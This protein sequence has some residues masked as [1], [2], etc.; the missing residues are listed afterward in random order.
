MQF[1]KTEHMFDV[2]S[3]PRKTGDV[4]EAASDDGSADRA[5]NPAQPITAQYCDCMC[6][7]TAQYPHLLPTELPTLSLSYPSP[8][9][10]SSLGLNWKWSLFHRGSLAGSSQY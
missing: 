5:G 9:A 3:S 2:A 8:A 1:V 10:R 4:A 6:P 7:I